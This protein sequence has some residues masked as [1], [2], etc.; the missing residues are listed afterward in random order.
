MAKRHKKV[1]AVVV[2]VPAAPPTFN[3]D[4][5]C[6]PHKREGFVGADSIKFDGVDFVFDIG[7][8]TFPW[9]DGSV[10]EAH[11]SH[12]VEH[13]DVRQRTHFVN[14]LHRVLKP[15]GKCTVI[16]PHW[17]SCRAYG[18]PTHAWP[19]VSEFWFYYLSQDWRNAN[20]PHTDVKWNPLGF[21][22]NFQATW[23]YALRQDIQTRPQEYQMF[24]V[25]NYKEACQDTMATLTKV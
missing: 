5:G 17:A 25:D 6:G 14:E 12:F 7:V 11:A 16:V 21:S 13:L 1:I 2:E 19:P 23:G 3:V 9:D 10:D 24:A 15:G 8:E 22:C 4:F 18:D 20:A